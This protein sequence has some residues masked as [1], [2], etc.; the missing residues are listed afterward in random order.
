MVRNWFENA[1]SKLVRKRR[2]EPDRRADLGPVKL[3]CSQFCLNFGSGQPD[4]GYNTTGPKPSRNFQ[5]LVKHYPNSTI[6]LPAGSPPVPPEYISICT[7]FSRICPDFLPRRGGLWITHWLRAELQFECGTRN[8]ITRTHHVIIPCFPQVLVHFRLSPRRRIR[9][10]I[11]SC[12]VGAIGDVR[13][14]ERGLEEEE[15]KLVL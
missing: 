15:N 5:E 13:R 1:G 2:F 6:A 4:T 7:Y 11:L 9:I 14:L 12:L 3:K 10:L 8:S